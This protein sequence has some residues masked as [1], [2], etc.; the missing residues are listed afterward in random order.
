MRW[1]HS[2]VSLS[3]AG[4]FGKPCPATSLGSLPVHPHSLCHGAAFS[5]VHHR[6]SVHPRLCQDS[7]I[8]ECS[9]QLGVC[10][11]LVGGHRV[12]NAPSLTA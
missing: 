12:E 2:S 10:V 3:S 4:R 6:R 7:I 8:Q 11:H 9:L 1:M 5:P